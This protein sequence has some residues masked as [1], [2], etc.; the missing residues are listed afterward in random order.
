[1][2]RLLLSILLA[3]AFALPAHATLKVGDAAPDFTLQA[4]E[5][6]KQFTFSLADAEKKGPVVVY[7][8]PKAFTKGCSIEA[9]DFA[10]AIDQYHA[11]GAT[12]I[13]VSH[14]EIATLDKFSVQVCQSKFPVAADTD[15]AVM[16]AWDTVLPQHAE[17]ADR[18]SYVINPDGKVIYTFTDLEPDHHVENTLNAVKLWKA[19]R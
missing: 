13:G 18:T 8:Y 11:L 6:G 4:S 1:M 7:F 9:H 19:S 2:N 15:G 14:D 3:S 16:K 17:Y 10:A 5:A 12:V